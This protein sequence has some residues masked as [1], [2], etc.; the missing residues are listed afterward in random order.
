MQ[1]NSDKVSS[2]KEAMA[3]YPTGVTV[4][5]TIDE[6]GNP[7]GLTV[8]SFASVSLDPLLILWS[9]DK[10]VSTYESFKKVDKFA[11]NI[12]ADNQAEIASVFASRTS[13]Q[14]RFE[15]S[16]WD[17]SKNNLPIIK[18]AMA[19]LQCKTFKQIEAGDHT[20]IIGEIS[21]IVVEKKSPLVYQGRKM[22]ALPTNFHEN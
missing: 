5:T 2:F 12:L 13:N 20:I 4:V 6:E 21:E 1:I 3:N 10:R 14:E 15:K 8:N 16:D 17:L 19:T 9:I 18:R 11:V 7:I 22:G